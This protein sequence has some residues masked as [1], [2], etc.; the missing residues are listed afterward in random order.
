MK[1][2]KLI[3]F[4]EEPA[5]L[6][7]LDMNQIRGGLNGSSGDCNCNNQCGIQT[8]DKTPNLSID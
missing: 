7:V 5:K 8:I 2:K 6:D 1:T 3:R 4:I